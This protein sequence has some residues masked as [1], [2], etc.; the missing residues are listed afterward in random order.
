[1]RTT[2]VGIAVEQGKQQAAKSWL[3]RLFGK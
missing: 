1:V 3:R 2:A